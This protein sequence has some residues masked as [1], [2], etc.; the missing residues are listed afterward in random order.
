MRTRS[1]YAERVNTGYFLDIT[2]KR[3][4]AARYNL[5]ID[6]VNEIIQSSVGGLNVTTTIEGRGR[7]PVNIRYAR[8]LRSDV[9]SLKRVLLPLSFSL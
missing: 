6:D 1:V 8:E 5:T 9:D 4:K 2:I 7:Y 3:E